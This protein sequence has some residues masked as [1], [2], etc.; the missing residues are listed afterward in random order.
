ME[1]LFSNDLNDFAQDLVITGDEFKHCKALRLRQNEK[2]M[3]TNGFGLSVLGIVSAFDKNS[4]NIRIIDRFTN[5]NEPDL[6]INLA[7][8]L[9]SDRDRNEF[10]IEKGV[11]LGVNSFYPLVTDFSQQTHFKPDRFKNKAISALKQ[12][13]RSCMPKINE[14]IK[15]DDLLKQAKEFERLILFS[16]FGN[17][18]ESNL[19]VD[20][21]LYLVGPEGGFSDREI[22][23]FNEIDNKALWKI[24]NRRLRTETAAIA[25]M[26]IN[27]IF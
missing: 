6:K 21:I 3:V 8:G 27:N 26:S 12:S 11:E 22:T 23:L 4:Y 5:L 25:A 17:K 24:G 14:L 20:N 7:F 18:P 10:I 15:F 9:L 2:I 19:L 1:C 13:K 16:E